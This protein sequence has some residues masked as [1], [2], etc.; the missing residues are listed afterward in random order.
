MTE[1]TRFQILKLLSQRHYCVRVLALRLGISESAVSQ[2]LHILKK[3]GVVD[4]KRIGYHAHYMVNREL[5]AELL[6]EI[7]QL[8]PNEEMDEGPM[9]RCSCEFMPECIRKEGKGAAP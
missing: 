3:Y 2:H 9:E 5:I 6:N 7:L 1:P 4:S 8:I